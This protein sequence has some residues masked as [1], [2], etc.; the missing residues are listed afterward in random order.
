MRRALL[1]LPM[2]VMLADERSTR[3]WPS[4]HQHAS[5][6]ADQSTIL[7]IAAPGKPPSTTMQMARAAKIARLFIPRPCIARATSIRRSKGSF[8]TIPRHV[9]HSKRRIIQFR[10]EMAL[11]SRVA[12]LQEPSQRLTESRCA[13]RRRKPLFAYFMT[14]AACTTSTRPQ[15]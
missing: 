7:A 4:V 9:S 15:P 11:T 8:R 5:L 2:P 6:I 13:S 1:V 3:R 12:Q 10:P 14:D